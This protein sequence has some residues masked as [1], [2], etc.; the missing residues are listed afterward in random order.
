[1]E[2]RWLYVTSE[3]LEKLRE[4]T[5]GVCVIPMGAVEKHGLH[6]P[7]GTDI[8][9]GSYIAHMAS[10]MEPVCIFADFPFGDMSSGNA[11]APCGTISLPM[12]TEFLLLEQLCDQ[13]GRYG[14][15]KIVLYNSHGGNSAWL[16]A[17]L[18]QLGNKKKDYTVCIF[19]ARINLVYQ[20]STYLEEHGPGSLPELTAEDEAIVLRYH[21][22]KIPTGHGCFGETA[23]VMGCAPETV[24]L[25]RLGIESGKS[26]HLTDHFKQAGIEIRDSGWWQDYPNSYAAEVDPVDCNER[27][28]KAAV[29]LE[30]ERAANAFR[31]LKEDEGLL[32]WHDQRQKDWNT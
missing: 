2:T 29:R 23:L 16:T 27:I 4:E 1:M 8:I 17:F 3:E 18:Q 13:I 32:K 6:L 5:K 19:R 26:L 9:K 24:K 31:V 12:Q 22:N 14:F 28:G 11:S 15:R 7:L 30:A 25:H 21:N 10:Q 20:I